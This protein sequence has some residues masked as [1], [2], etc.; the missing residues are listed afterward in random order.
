LIAAPHSRFR[1]TFRARHDEVTFFVAQAA[2]FSVVL[3]TPS[4]TSTPALTVHRGLGA[5]RR[6]SWRSG[7]KKRLRQWHG[8]EPSMPINGRN[9]RGTSSKKRLTLRAVPCEGMSTRSTRVGFRATCGAPRIPTSCQGRSSTQRTWQLSC[10]LRPV[11]LSGT[12]RDDCKSVALPSTSNE[13]KTLSHALVLNRGAIDHLFER[14]NVGT[15]C[16]VEIA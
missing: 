1:R 7:N 15:G 6:S 5:T 2:L 9:H 10:L 8:P 16:Y 12:T 4:D 13:T 14:G 11:C 3:P